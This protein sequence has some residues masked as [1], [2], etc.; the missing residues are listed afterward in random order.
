MKRE[1][2]IGNGEWGIGDWGFMYFFL[3]LLFAFFASSRFVQ[4][5]FFMGR[6]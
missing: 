6:K 4:Y 5:K 3:L 1:L 2:G